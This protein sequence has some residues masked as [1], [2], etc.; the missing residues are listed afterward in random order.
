MLLHLCH[1]SVGQHTEVT[2]GGVQGLM[3]SLPESPQKFHLDLAGTEVSEK[4]LERYA[5]M[6]SAC[7]PQTSRGSF[8]TL[9]TCLIWIS[10]SILCGPMLRRM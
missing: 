1:L 10:F 5:G 8:S 4:P 6:S 2:D 3:Q 9:T 7:S